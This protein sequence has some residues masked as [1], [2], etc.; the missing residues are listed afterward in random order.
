MWAVTVWDQ[1]WKRGRV[2]Q[3]DLPLRRELNGEQQR[4]AEEFLA[5]YGEDGLALALASGPLVSALRPGSKWAYTTVLGA[6]ENGVSVVMLTRLSSAKRT[7]DRVEHR[8]V[9]GD[10]QLMVDFPR[11]E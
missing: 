9:S 3:P 2:T 7:L 5:E 1:R 8:L 6:Y 10:A 11:A 4:K